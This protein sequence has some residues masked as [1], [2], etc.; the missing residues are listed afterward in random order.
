MHSRRG[1]KGTT[2]IET[3]FAIGVMG[4]I[5]GMAISLLTISAKNT[6]NQTS[7]SSFQ[8]GVDDFVYGLLL[9]MK[10]AQGVTVSGYDDFPVLH[11]ELQDG[12]IV[13]YEVNN[14]RGCIYRNRA[15]T[16]N[17]IA[18]GIKKCFFHEEDEYSVTLTIFLTDSES[19]E[20]T[21]RCK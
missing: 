2:L 17:P 12:S 19:I 18:E 13:T 4:L 9:E 8:R 10:S 3:I 11:V 15:E 1:R 14:L 6:R 16:P 5:V 21:L 7:A 20:Y